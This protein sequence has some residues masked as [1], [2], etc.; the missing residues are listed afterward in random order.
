[1]A[2][3]NMKNSKEQLETKFPINRRHQ[4]MATVPVAQGRSLGSTFPI[5]R[6]HQRMATRILHFVWLEN[7]SR[8]PINRRHQR[9]AT[10]YAIA[11]NGNMQA[12]FQSIGVTK[13]WRRLS[14]RLAPGFQ[15]LGFQSIGVTKEWRLLFR[16]RWSSLRLHRF[17]INRRHQRMATPEDPDFLS[18]SLSTFPINRRHQRMATCPFDSGR[19]GFVYGFQS[20]GVTK[21]WRPKAIY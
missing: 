13:E 9:M 4:R 21:E 7:T 11:I 15:P 8:F 2:T 5:N 20:I 14:Q 19:I 12:G 3:Q 18:L 17:P 1:M 6:R 16:S 10:I